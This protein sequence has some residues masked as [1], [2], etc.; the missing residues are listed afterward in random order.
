MRFDA[1][2]NRT[3]FSVVSWFCGT[4]PSALHLAVVAVVLGASFCVAG[5]G[6][7]RGSGG[8][9]GAQLSPSSSQVA[10]GNVVVGSSTSNLVT[11][12]AAGNKSVTISSVSA[13]GTGFVVS[14]QSNVVLAPSQ[15]LTVSVSFEPKSTGSATGQ[16]LVASNASNGSLKISLS[17][18]GVTSSHSVTLNWQ[19][20]ASAVIG[21]FVF[22][23]STT[24]TLSQLTTNAV[25]STSYTDKTI[26]DGQT[27]VY[28][29]KSINSSNALSGFSNIV[30]VSVPG[31]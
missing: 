14:P 27:Y 15:S 24:S 13:S 28:A 18:A 31:N 4:L 30:T 8:A 1:A 16:L 26:A 5:C 3:K 17:G 29:V 19:P 25:A 10:F 9:N 21:Y 20:S 23:G 22:R 6:Q 11:I 2:G 12:T 7:T